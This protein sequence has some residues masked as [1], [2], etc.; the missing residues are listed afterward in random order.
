MDNAE[1]ESI[2]TPGI[3]EKSLAAARFAVEVEAASVA[4]LSDRLGSDF[5]SAVRILSQTNGKVIVGGLGKSGHIGRKV[6]ASLASTGTPAF[7]IHATE[8]LHGDAGMCIPADSALL[9]SN[10]GVRSVLYVLK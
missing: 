5:Q 6:A 10:S 8:A 3:W 1:T 4:A 7:F 9:I 2:Q